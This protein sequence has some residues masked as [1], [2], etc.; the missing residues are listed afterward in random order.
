MTIG[1]RVDKRERER[2]EWA[3]D[4]L[5][6]WGKWA[7][8]GGAPNGYGESCLTLEEIRSM[9]LRSFI[10]MSPPECEQL[11]EALWRLPLDLRKL[12]MAWYVEEL[13]RQKIGQRLGVSESHVRRLHNSLLVALEYC[14]KNPQAKV[15]PLHLLLKA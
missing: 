13:T 4:R 14:L 8:S 10:P 3:V 1:I 6:S 5:Q 11:H 2:L 15:L 9:P 12:A 7:K